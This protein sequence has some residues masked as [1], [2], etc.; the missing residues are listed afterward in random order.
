MV[1]S[2]QQNW[3]QSKLNSLYT[4]EAGMLDSLD[5]N[6]TAGEQAE[7]LPYDF[8]FEFPREKIVLGA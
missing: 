6:M 2:S 5:P 4:F 3:Q 8:K 7:F 1:M